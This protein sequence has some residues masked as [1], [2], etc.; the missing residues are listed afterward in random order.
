MA[1]LIK[2][3]VKN[4]T[5]YCDK[6]L[7]VGFWSLACEGESHVVYCKHCELGKELARKSPT[8]FRRIC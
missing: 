1:T 2:N 3:K 4:S 8:S 6:C 7:N 5:T